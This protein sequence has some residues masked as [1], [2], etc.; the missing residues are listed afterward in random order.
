MNKK[1]KD[2]RQNQLTIRLTDRENA[3]IDWYAER[4]N[5]DRANTPRQIV[6]A[7]I[8]DHSELAATFKAETGYG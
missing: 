1:Q 6:A 4:I 8:T 2:L 3:F 5:C 7:F